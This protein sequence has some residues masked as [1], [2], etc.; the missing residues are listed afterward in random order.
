MQDEIDAGMTQTVV[1]NY[2]NHD[3]WPSP[4]GVPDDLDW[5]SNY[6]VRLE[7]SGVNINS[8]QT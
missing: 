5:R 4:I 7:V 1:A 6:G 2:L 3:E 8:G